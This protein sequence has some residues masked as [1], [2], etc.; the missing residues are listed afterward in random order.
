MLE[1][2]HRWVDRQVE[3]MLATASGMH[4]DSFVKDCL[5]NPFR[6]ALHWSDQ[7]AVQRVKPTVRDSRNRDD[8]DIEVSGLCVP[9]ARTGDGLYHLIVNECDYPPR[10]YFTL[11]HELGHYLQ[12]TDTEL[13]INL[14][15]FDDAATAKEAEEAA[16][17]R[18]ASKALLPDSYIEGLLAERSLDA[19]FAKDLFEIG[20]RRTS[21][22]SHAGVS[23]HVVIRRLADFLPET[24]FI[25]LI[26]N[27]KLYTR[28]QGN[29]HIRYDDALLQEEREAIDLF[30]A[31]EVGSGVSNGLSITLDGKDGR[32]QIS[33]ACSYAWPDRWYFLIVK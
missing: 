17:N 8:E 32:K 21:T 25:S 33:I 9:P 26:K 16:C 20:R 22:K 10:N 11:L 4:P 12:R 13:A 28:I 14:F 1:S 19:I 23:R 6:I 18:F 31:H 24:G 15:M 3:G 7:V 2:T 5:S 30:L 27:E 29:R